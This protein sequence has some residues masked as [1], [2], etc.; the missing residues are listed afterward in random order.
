[1]AQTP[2]DAAIRT[3]IGRLI[4]DEQLMA[5]VQEKAWNYES[6]ADFLAGPMP[7]ALDPD[8]AWELVS[9]V[10]RM[11]GWPPV[12]SQMPRAGKALTPDLA[13]QT[14]PPAVEQTISDLAARCDRHSQLWEVLEPLVRHGR[15]VAPLAEDLAAAAEREGLSLSYEAV[16]ALALG[17][18]EPQRAEERIVANTAALLREPRQAMEAPTAEMLRDLHAAI[19]EG[20]AALG[21]AG[22]AGVDSANPPGNVAPESSVPEAFVLRRVN[23]EELAREISQ[24]GQWGAHPLPGIIMNAG[25]LW[26]SI[27][28]GPANAFLEIVLRRRALMRIGL[29]VL[30]WVPLSWLRLSWERGR[31]P[32]LLEPF[33]YGEAF[34]VSEF[35]LDC[36]PYLIQMLAMV[37]HYVDRLEE[38]ARALAAADA[39]RRETV[40]RDARLS[41]RQKELLADLIADPAARTDVG[42][43]ARRF[44]CAVSTA[45]DDLNRLVDLRY[46]STAYQGKKQVFWL[47]ETD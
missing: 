11:S 20:A 32:E 1:M 16:R 38:E 26:N 37:E 5:F 24:E 43:Y 14:T 28:I 19:M 47:N 21:N 17:A 36:T 45:R 25:I 29:P 46:C 8:T 9:F 13:F 2:A 35:G 34:L 33:R 42:A 31:A 40:S 44:D 3:E 39:A 22:Y 30:A 12:R 18:R 27:T 7:C 6:K 15:I 23:F 10:R 41:H 4:H